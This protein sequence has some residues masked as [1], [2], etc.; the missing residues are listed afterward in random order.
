[1]GDKLIGKRFVPPV[2]KAGSTSKMAKWIVTLLVLGY[3]ICIA[4]SQEKE[5]TQGVLNLDPPLNEDPEDHLTDDSLDSA[6]KEYKKEVIETPE[7]KIDELDTENIESSEKRSH[8][9]G[10][11][12]FVETFEFYP[13]GKYIYY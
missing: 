9:S 12:G 1:M 6:N 3:Y 4:Y 10:D 8:I 13:D 2:T 11:E 5:L 7:E